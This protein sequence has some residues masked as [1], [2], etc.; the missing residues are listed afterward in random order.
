MKKLQDLM[1]DILKE[2]PLLES[3]HSIIDAYFHKNVTSYTDQLENIRVITDQTPKELVDESIRQIGF[4][5]PYW[6]MDANGENIRRCFYHLTQ[7]Y[8]INGTQYYPKFLEFLLDR[9]FRAICL[10]TNDYQSF[11]PTPL[12]KLIHEGGQWFST[13]HVDLEV[14]INGILGQYPLV[15]SDEDIVYIKKVLDFD[16]Q[17][18]WKRDDIEFDISRMVES[19]TVYGIND[20]LYAYTIIEKRI[21]DLFYEFAPIEEVVRGIYLTIATQ[22]ELFLSGSMVEEGIDFVD[23]NG[24][25]PE[26]FVL[27]LNSMLSA[28]VEYNVRAR[29]IWSNE[30]ETTELAEITWADHGYQQQ[31]NIVVFNDIEGSLRQEVNL[32]FMCLGRRSQTRITLYQGGV[33]LVPARIILDTPSF[34][35]EG[36]TNLLRVSGDFRG[37]QGD[38]K[39]RDIFDVENVVFTTDNE[40]LVVEGNQISV[41]R[42]FSDIDATI[43]AEYETSEGTKIATS[44]LVTLKALPK[45]VIPRFINIT[46]DQV[47][48][49]SEGIV[50]SETPH[51]GDFIQGND[52]KINTW[53][54]YSDGSSKPLNTEV[55]CS[56]LAITI[57]SDRTFNV[58]DVGADF[59][60]TFSTKYTEGEEVVT[61]QVNVL[62]VY[63]QIELSQLEIT[64][65]DIIE[66]GSTQ[67]YSVIAHWSNGQISTVPDA[68]LASVDATLGGNLLYKLDVQNRS[69]TAPVL[70]RT[71]QGQLTAA[72]QR[73]TDGQWVEVTK[74]VTIKNND[75]V[76]SS[77]IIG[78]PDRLV[79]GQTMA[80]NF[81]V[82]WTDGKTTQVLPTS[83]RLI[84]Q[85]SG[86]LLSSAARLDPIDTSLEE[87]GFG[88]L[89]ISKH[90][91]ETFY[92]AET[93]LDCSVVTI[94]YE[95]TDGGVNGLI[96][97]EVL[98]T[99]PYSGQNI[100]A[101]RLFTT[102]EQFVATESVTIVAPTEIM[103]GSRVF[104]RA[105]VRYEDGSD[106]DS[107]A[108]WDITDLDGE[109]EDVGADISQGSFFL[110]KI[111]HSLIGFNE[112]ELLDMAT[113][114][115]DLSVEHAQRLIAGE[116][117]FA[118]TIN[119]PIVGQTWPQKLMILFATYEDILF[120]R[121]V[122]QTRF[123]TEDE[124]IVINCNF[125]SLRDS[126]TIKVVNR[127]S[128][129]DTP[130]LS[131]Y[132]T[133]PVEI[134]A[135]LYN[136][137]SYG[138]TV[139]YADN[140]IEYL[141]SNDWEVELFEDEVFNQRRELIRAIVLR[142]GDGILPM[143]N[144][145]S[146]RK[147]DVDELDAEEL[148]DVLPTSSVVDI[149]Q[150][151][152]LYPR[153][154]EN[155]R[156]IVKALYNDGQ[157]QFTESL[158][159][160]IRKQNTR[161]QKIEIALVGPTG[162]IT[163]DFKDKLIDEPNAWA[164][165]SLDGV[166][167]YQFRA[168]LTRFGDPDPEELIENLFWKA[169]PVGSGISF[170]EQSGKLY[171]LQ[172]TNDSD[173]TIVASYEEEFRES[174]TS[175]TVF[176]ESIVAR[177]LVMI[178]ATK[179][180]DII[181]VTG[182]LF[183]NSDT[184][185]YPP[186]NLIRRDG[187]N[188][189]LSL[190]TLAVVDA[191]PE[192]TISVDRQG[193]TIPKLSTDI[194]VTIRA[195][196]TEG[197]KTVIK[198]LQVTILASF[199]PL[200]LHVDSNPAG[201][202]D[203]SVYHLKAFLDMRDGSVYDGTKD[204]YWLLETPVAGV[205]VGNRTG[206]LTSGMVPVDTEIVIRVVYTRKELVY[207][208]RHTM[209]L[210]SSYPIYWEDPVTLINSA[211]LQSV[212]TDEDFKRLLSTEGGRVTAYPNA[213]E[214]FY[215]A[216]QKILGEANFAIIPSTTGAIDWG[217][218]QD[219][220]EVTR[221]YINGVT[222]IWRV[223]RT[224][225]RGFTLG[226]FSVVYA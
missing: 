133:G 167:F 128:V 136:F 185:F 153:L 198:D 82:E 176:L 2:D 92:E 57:D 104:L 13:T 79:E 64:G 95:D 141:V 107:S 62:C 114:N 32:E 18:Q 139:Q 178:S 143:D 74:I 50:V 120:P 70:G 59:V 9:G 60:N 156:I 140:G 224:K 213:N 48:F 129:P 61:A 115:Q 225:N 127:P 217:G 10:F 69:V 42:I 39:F 168:Y 54:V 142:D 56:S 24:P 165:V 226:E 106:K 201:I 113:S 89:R 14:D 63:P 175:S 80:A 119:Q 5:L 205:S 38:A 84:K 52:Y 210:Q 88:A 45:D 134:E 177:S 199:V 174:E 100:V 3:A 161:L 36:S 108:S 187:S 209:I 184:T 151:G 122:V 158:P 53:I 218:M 147:K 110:S 33:E 75:R 1:V 41:S 102:S 105:V 21:V 137:Y 159:V 132:I 182:S 49:N 121:C 206:V 66:E 146:G 219:P 34:L 109:T 189:D 91:T 65:P 207:E 6:I 212:F 101:N 93:A 214:Y 179:A 203:N 103:E 208:Q 211:Y 85:D 40:D 98:Y 19:G 160:Y 126:K 172:Q 215:F 150:N 15:L 25:Y 117:L 17:P 135:N 163:F 116:S 194:V 118:E 20:A 154:N 204:C 4:D 181:E 222:E 169:E 216:C 180:L 87:F 81:Y 11:Y 94:A 8:Q 170:D 183:T 16:N 124:F 44:K 112:T 125:F 123:I 190:I 23:L 96:S 188:A 173:I 35:I 86:L 195:S 148:L 73:Y 51:T 67:N 58:S 29:V 223:Y 68:Q 197:L 193:V 144:D 97:M 90:D 77:L 12:G 7:V 171:I 164:D 22:A 72:V 83:I 55:N 78:I 130:I 220:V 152:Y 202:R 157:Q 145:G 76:A 47:I 186:L 138:L 28:N 46:F 111:V 131:W 71:E 31:D 221:T 196:A 37:P 99:D 30:S 149:D 43:T 162:S 26:R 200:A 155:V 166:V 192:I 27:E 191:P